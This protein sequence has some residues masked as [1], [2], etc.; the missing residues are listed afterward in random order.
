MVAVLTDYFPGPLNEMHVLSVGSSA[1]IIDDYL[2]DHFHSVVGIDIDE[3]AIEHARKK[4]Q[5]ANL[6][7]Q[8]GDALNLEFPDNSFE[9]VICSQVYEHV[10]NP[11]KMLDELF[12]VLVPGGVCYFAAG[13]RL[14]WNEPHYNLPLLSVVPRPVANFY[15]RLAKK[16][17]DYHELHYTYWGLRKLVRRF[18][19]HDYTLK[20]IC[21]PLKYH[22]DYMVQPGSIKAA[23]AKLIAGNLLWLSPGYIWLLEKPKS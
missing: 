14:M 22:T 1:G 23:I 16:A 11:Q 10:P 20:T 19:L 8:V 12:R 15:V 3:P 5:K 7:F 21:S 2:A 9:V 18:V 17:G 13:N 4:F 6:S